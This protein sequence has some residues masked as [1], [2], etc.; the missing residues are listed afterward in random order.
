MKVELTQAQI[1]HITYILEKDRDECYEVLGS[2]SADNRYC[3]NSI[4]LSNNI[5]QKLL[6]EV[7]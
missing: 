5:L 7:A 6:K 4:N 1:K 2:P 3:R